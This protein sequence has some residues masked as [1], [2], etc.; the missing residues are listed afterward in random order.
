M[1]LSPSSSRLSRRVPLPAPRGL[2]VLQSRVA[3]RVLQTNGLVEHFLKLSSSVLI[4]QV[5]CHEPLG[6]SH[7]VFFQ[8]LLR[9]TPDLLSPVLVLILH[10]LDHFL[11]SVSHLLL[12]VLIPS[13]LL[14]GTGSRGS[15]VDG[16][17][18]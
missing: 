2:R 13:F 7:F 3:G 14:R 11:H 16:A 18:F 15:L 8:E 5:S 4:P 6:F 1:G 9:V 12:R 10:L 17:T